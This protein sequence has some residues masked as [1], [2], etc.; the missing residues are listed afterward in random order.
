MKHILFAIGLAY[1][2]LP[3]YAQQ[4][5]PRIGLTLSKTAAENEAGIEQKIKPGF[6]LG[7]GVEF[8]ISSAFSIQPELNFIQK[9]FRITFDE[10]DQGISLSVDNRT[11]IN[12]LEIPLLFKV[13]FGNST[14]KYFLLGGVSVGYGLGGKT[15]TKV[16][17]DLMGTGFS[18]STTG[19]VKF[20]DPPENYNPEEDTDLYLNNR[21]DAG[22]QFGFGALINEKF[23]VEAR[24]NVG[25]SPFIDEEED[26]KNRVLQV[27]FAM[28]FSAIKSMTTK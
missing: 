25:F 8:K 14:T 9:G 10:S 23:I 22:A 16:D 4:V 20:S 5:V 3:S 13:Y 28:P 21:Y 24:Y 17:A 12:Y 27:S 19:K 18:V 26:T 7:A 11:A 1:A 15:K 6:T 2:C